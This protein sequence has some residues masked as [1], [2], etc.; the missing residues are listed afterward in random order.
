MTLTRPTL[1]PFPPA[2][3]VDWAKPGPCDAC[4]RGTPRRVDGRPLHA[5]HCETVARTRRR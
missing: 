1:V 5:G 2:V 3:T 4:G